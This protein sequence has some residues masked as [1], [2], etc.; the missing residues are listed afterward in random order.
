MGVRIFWYTEEQPRAKH[1][2]RASVFPHLILTLPCEYEVFLPHFYSALRKNPNSEKQRKFP[3]LHPEKG[4]LSFGK[5]MRVHYSWVAQ[6]LSL[7]RYIKVPD[8]SVDST[9][10]LLVWCNLN[11]AFLRCI[12]SSLM[13]FIV[14][15]DHKLTLLYCFSRTLHAFLGTLLSWCLFC[16]PP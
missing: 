12:I 13:C 7:H 1:W 4:S 16:D 2:A 3:S 11:V 14:N 6:S 9:D 8:N 15:A 5:E 10:F